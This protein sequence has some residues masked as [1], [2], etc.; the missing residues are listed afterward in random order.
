M[1]A[2]QYGWF[3]TILLRKHIL[4]LADLWEGGFTLEGVGFTGPY[5]LCD[6]NMVCSK[7]SKI[8]I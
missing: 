1:S 4:C 5:T 7:T 3:H 2:V 6:F 8:F